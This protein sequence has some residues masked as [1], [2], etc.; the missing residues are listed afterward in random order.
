MVKKIAYA[1][2]GAVIML[3]GISL[4]FALTEDVPEDEPDL[5][6]SPAT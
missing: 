4:F 5:Q 3:A 6:D 2:G 1:L